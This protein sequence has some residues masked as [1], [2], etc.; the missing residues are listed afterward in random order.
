VDEGP[1]FLLHEADGLGSLPVYSPASASP[2]AP[3]PFQGLFLPLFLPSSLCAE[4]A[5]LKFVS[6]VLVTYVHPRSSPRP[7][8]Y[9]C[10][11]RR[12]VSRSHPTLALIRALYVFIYCRQALYKSRILLYI[13]WHP[14]PCTTTSPSKSL[15]WT[16]PSSRAPRTSWT[17]PSPT[18]PTTR[19]SG[20]TTCT[21]RSRCPSV[22][23]VRH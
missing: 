3:H 11:T 12:D 21:A 16:L 15:Q 18:S 8:L 13:L 9:F 23:G 1:G 17:V 4:Y 22:V 2:S 19:C 7:L 5:T 14:R 6:V 10:P 20:S